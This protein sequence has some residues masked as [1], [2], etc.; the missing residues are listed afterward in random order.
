ML[1]LFSQEMSPVTSTNYSNKQIFRGML[2]GEQGEKEYLP[3]LE[4]GSK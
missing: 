3:N 1:R 4:N 2:R